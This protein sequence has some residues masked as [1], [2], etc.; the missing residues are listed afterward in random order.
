MKK[1]IIAEK[2]SL[3]MNIVQ[4]LGKG[5]T[6]NDGFF[7]NN[8][9]IVSFAFGH[10]FTLYDI[11]D[12]D[13]SKA[14]WT[15]ENLPFFPENNEFKFKLKDDVGV[16]KQYRILENLALRNDVEEIIHCGDSDIEGEVIGCLIINNI[17]KDNNF[18]KPVK[19]LWLVE[20][21]HETIRR[22]LRNM[23]NDSEYENYLNQGLARHYTDWL[24]G[25]NL[26]RFVSVKAGTLLP[27]GRVLTPIV[28]IIYDR[29]KEIENF[30]PEDYF[31]LESNEETNGEKIKLVFKEKF[32]NENDFKDIIYKLNNSKAYVLDI[33]KKDI[34]KQPLKLFSLSKLQGLLSKKFKMNMKETLDIVQKL[35]E[36]G[37]VT[38]PRT[39]T[40]YLAENEK[41]K[42]KNIISKL[43]KEN[44]LEFKDKKTIFD[45]KKIESHS[46]IIPTGKDIENMNLNENELKVYK[47]IKNRFF[48]NFLKED[49]ILTKT[50]ITVKIDDYK[51][52][53]KG[54]IIKQV[55]FMKLEDT[56]SEDII[57]PNLNLNDEINHK[58]I[59]VA[60]K[61]TAPKK[62]NIETLLNTLKNPFK[63]ILNEN[64][65]KVYEG[66]LNG[67]EL[68]TEA[69]RATIIEHAKKNQYISEKDTVFSI[70][71][72]GNLL[73]ETLEKLEIDLS[74]EKTIEISKQLKYIFKSNLS[75]KMLL[76]LLRDEIEKTIEKSKNINI[77]KN[78]FKVEKEVIGVCPRCNKNVYEGSKSYYCEGYK[79]EPKCEFVIWK[80]NKFFDDKGKKLTKTM[81]KNFLLGKEVLVKG[82]KK[83]DGSGTYDCKVAMEDTGKYVNFKLIF[84]DI[85]RE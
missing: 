13:S 82:F 25:I 68:G 41:V 43:D 81:V 40:E 32:K 52:E 75:K 46:A 1:L 85:V 73:I 39:N 21:T 16:R 72:K 51:F 11:K 38:Y 69:T 64:E 9:Y 28:R 8:K 78:N 77:N 48:S 4:S 29:N 19:R 2:P 24:L 74:K 70:E 67:L 37:L 27:V 66:I 20:Q 63:D 6:K 83:K 62:I 31:Q 61:T 34:I 80:R 56:K 17:F 65:E 33:N 42:V 55:G 26:T 35:Y 7:E 30:I 12:Y 79:N 84:K 76:S 10:L 50:I 49:T 58:F 44:I 22:E 59:P 23:K 14:L 53:L 54:E 71:K 36:N 15:V 47:V 5:F 57:L 3:A 45:D 18:Q 60:K